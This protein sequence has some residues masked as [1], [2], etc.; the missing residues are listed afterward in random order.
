MAELILEWRRQPRQLAF[1]RACGLDHPFSGGTP[2][3]AV[4]NVIG[5]GG[6]AGGGK[7][8][9]LLMAGIIG[10]LTFPGLKVAFFRRKGVELE[11]LGGAI[12]RSREL[13]A[14]AADAGYV[15]WNGRSMRW[16][17]KNGSMLQF[18]HCNEES[19][20]HSYQSQQFDILLF[21]E[22][23]HFS[24]YIY[25]YLLSRN[26]KT[27]AAPN[28]TPFA[29]IATNPGGEG[30]GWF[31]REFVDPGPPEQVHRVE[32]EPGKY[33]YH[34]FLPAFLDD[35]QALVE[36]DPEYRDRLERLPE[37]ERRQLLYGDWNA[38]AGQYYPEWEQRL[39]V[40]N[41]DGW[42]LAP[43][44][45]RF[46]SLD[47]G[48]DMTACHWWAVDGSGHCIVYR[49]LCEPGLRLSQ[50]AEAILDLSP[51]DENI[52]YT[53]AAPD[54]WNRRQDTGKSGREILAAA[55]L[56]GLVRADNRRV[57]GWRVLREYLAPI[58]DEQ[59]QRS[60]RLRFY[61]T[62]TEAIR[63]IPL[64]QR[65]RRDPEDA[66]DEPHEITHAPESIR[67]GIMSR[68][69][70]RSVDP[71]SPEERKRRRRRQQITIPISPY[72]GY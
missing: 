20:V 30:H 64:L 42:P 51:P 60:A 40:I 17:W 18:C 72:T 56:K 26:R 12:M 66:A 35:N 31:K 41:P 47:Y 15:R 65:D 55:G 53:V 4:A 38:F 44:Y 54:L 48:L 28:F 10:G 19:D 37:I 23:T 7:S 39:H 46:R 69:P 61:S 5:Y 68:P 63:C 27:V 49:E 25:R 1:L 58:I 8:D 50:A 71:D 67:Y 70:I 21:D 45:K 11:G 6:A 36:R 3:P 52:S 13:L 22:G 43:W 29:A 14:G 9:A 57:P 59:G 16:T 34:L 62:C 32:V 2:R 24:E 33:E